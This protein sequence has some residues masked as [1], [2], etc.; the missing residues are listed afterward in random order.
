MANPLH[1]YSQ[2]SIIYV[3]VIQ[4]RYLTN[5]V[6]ASF[7]SLCPLSLLLP[8]HTH[9]HSYTNN[10]LSHTHSHTF[11]FTHTHTQISTLHFAQSKQS[12][13]LP[14]RNRRCWSLRKSSFF[15]F[16]CHCRSPFPKYH[17][18]RE[19]KEGGRKERKSWYMSP[20][21]AVQAVRNRRLLLPVCWHLSCHFTETLGCFSLCSTHA[22][23]LSAKAPCCDRMRGWWVVGRG[24]QLGSLRAELQHPL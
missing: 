12:P 19:E 20:S 13:E 10:T 23:S 14:G 21:P 5:P 18:G 17:P 7:Y 16:S 2:Y 24:I 11:S 22:P 8:K 1:K 6:F 9:T 15:L 4:G 3:W